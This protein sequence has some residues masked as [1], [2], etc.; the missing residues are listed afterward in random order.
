[1]ES[2]WDQ[3]LVQLRSSLSIQDF[4]AWIACL[5]TSAAPGDALTVERSEVV[6]S[7]G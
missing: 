7:D 1:M 6:G 4:T 3:T 2:L 5:R